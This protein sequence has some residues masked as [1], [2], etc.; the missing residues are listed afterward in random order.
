M[1]HNVY[2]HIESVQRANALTD[3]ACELYKP[4][5]GTWVKNKKGGEFSHWVPKNLIYM[6][7]LV[8]RVFESETPMT[9]IERAEN[10]IAEF[11]GK[12]TIKSSAG[13]F[14]N[15]FETDHGDDNDDGQ[16]EEWL[17]EDA[18]DLMRDLDV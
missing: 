7:E 1:G 2:Q 13:A 14:N 4:D 8:N 15:L 3:A 16:I 9:E 6:V 11:N 5:P 12:R 10:L 17:E 18:D